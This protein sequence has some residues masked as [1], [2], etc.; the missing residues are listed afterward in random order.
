[1]NLVLSGKDGQRQLILN[2]SYLAYYIDIAR[3]VDI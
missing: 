2:G 1:M 3:A